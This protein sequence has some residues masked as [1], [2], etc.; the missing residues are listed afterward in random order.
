MWVF[1]LKHKWNLKY[2]GDYNI[3][4]GIAS[5]LLSR[6]HAALHAPLRHPRAP[7]PPLRH[8]DLSRPLLSLISRRRRLR[9]HRLPRKDLRETLQLQAG[10]QPGT[11]R[12][13]R[14]RHR[15]LLLLLLPAC[16]LALSQRSRRVVWLGWVGGVTQSPKL[17]ST[18]SSRRC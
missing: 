3:V 18:T 7:H 2:L 12:H 10:R 15:R 14:R 9:H 4:R 16:R 1:D 5:S 17:R 6:R 13:G 11:H 8:H